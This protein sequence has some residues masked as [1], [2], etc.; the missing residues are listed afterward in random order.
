LLDLC[1]ALGLAPTV[2]DRPP[3]L[4]IPESFTLEQAAERRK[5]LAQFYANYAS[6]FVL[7]SV[8]EAIRPQV[9]QTAEENYE[10]LLEPAR[11]LVLSQLR[12][13]GGGVEETPTRWQSVL[14]WLREPK[15]LDDWRVLATVLSRLRD[16]EG[17]DP[18]NAL[19]AFLKQTSFTLDVR[20]LTLEIPE[21]LGVKPAADAKLSIY[22]P[23]SAGEKPALV[24]EQSSE[25]Q[26]DAPRRVWT[27]SFRPVAGQR[28]TYHPGDAL[29]AQLPL[30]DD[31]M[32]TWVRGRTL[33]YQFERLLRPPRLHR[34]KEAAVDGTLEKKIRLTI[35]PAEG[36]PRL[37]DLMPVVRLEKGD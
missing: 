35:S 36:V 21:S 4:V 20:R 26:R 3:A 14:R 17:G 1:A 11:A 29:W 7:N 2:R 31:W 32:L 30:R 8:P 34:S 33:M 16:P 5:Q 27:Y 24:F 25:G 15:E 37:P 6:D 10:H 22:H 28:L 12:Q 19:S 23:G 9:R 13:A 18:V